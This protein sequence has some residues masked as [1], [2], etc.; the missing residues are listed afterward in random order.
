M[1][2]KRQR[3]SYRCG[4]SIHDLTYFRLG[5]FYRDQLK[6]EDRALESYLEVCDRTTWAPWGR[7]D[8]PPKK[9]VLTGDDET[10]VRATEAACAILRK[11]GDL[12]RVKELQDSLAKAQAEAKAALQK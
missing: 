7:A 2:E 8:K 12:A 4:E 11:R 9:T 6:D 10:L 5:N 3:L 1:N